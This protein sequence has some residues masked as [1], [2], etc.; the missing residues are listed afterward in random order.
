MPQADPTVGTRPDIGLAL[1]G[2]GSRAMAF[3]LGC[4][5]AL[6]DEGLLD[7]VATISAVSGGSV[8]A[9]LYC[10]TP[11]DFATFEVKTQQLLKRGFLRPA[12]LQAVSSFEGLKALANFAAVGTDRLLAFVVCRVL[13]GLRLRKRFKSSWLAQS[14]I[15]RSASRTTILRKVFSQVFAHQTLPSLRKDRPKLII[16]A[17]ELQTKSAFYFAAD[18][19]GSWHFGSAAPEDMEIAHAVSASA[20]YPAALPPLD[21]VLTFTKNDVAECHRVILTDGGVYDNL[22][23]APL[24]P[25]RDPTIS[26]HVADYPRI[27]ACRAGYGLKHAARPAF[28]VSRLKAAFES[29]HAR[30]QNFAM[31]RLYDLQRGGEIET[32]LLPYIDQKDSLLTHAPADL[33]TAEDVA[34]YPTDFSAMPEEWIDRLS[35]RGEQVTR[36]LVKQYWSSREQAVG[37][38]VRNSSGG[39]P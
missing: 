31:N 9:A 13:G 12:I 7:Q 16:V 38:P 30:A 28:M 27:I 21:E 18:A 39:D 29:V 10:Q 22:A 24:W 19:V 2:G 5:R 25:G 11:G 37:D 34:D 26:L 3:H 23:L 15:R 36:A 4:L 35:K 14:S 32:F 33:V 20:A 1:S 6:H 8:L 17:C